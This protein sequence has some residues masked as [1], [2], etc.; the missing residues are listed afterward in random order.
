MML[1]SQGVYF[2]G[3]QVVIAWKSTDVFAL[4]YSTAQ[5]SAVMPFMEMKI[6][7]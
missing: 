1:H 2:M 4:C 5:L 3:K 7:C 6:Q